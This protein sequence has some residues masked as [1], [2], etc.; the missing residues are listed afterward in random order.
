MPA[1]RSETQEAW[2]G[3][4]GMNDGICD[5]YDSHMLRCDATGGLIGD[6]GGVGVFRGGQAGLYNVHLVNSTA[7]S[8]NLGAALVARPRRAGALGRV[9]AL[10]RRRGAAAGA[11]AALARR[12]QL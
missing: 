8:R 1:P 12:A 11:L 4:L 9:P 7:S 10:R 6:G 3:G 2:G 5:V